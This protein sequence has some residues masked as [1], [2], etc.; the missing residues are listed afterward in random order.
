VSSALSPSLAVKCTEK[1]EFWVTDEAAMQEKL[2]GLTARA[3]GV[4]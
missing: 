3:R 4:R 2:E 1:V